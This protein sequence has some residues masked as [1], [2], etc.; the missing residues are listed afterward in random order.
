M[1]DLEHIDEEMIGQWNRPGDPMGHLFK[2]DGNAGPNNIEGPW[3]TSDEKII[4]ANTDCP[5]WTIDDRY[6]FTYQRLTN[7]WDG[8]TA[9]RQMVESVQ[10]LRNAAVAS[11]NWAPVRAYFMAN[12]DY[13][14]TM[15]YIAIRNWAEPWDDVFH[16]H[17][18]YQ[19]ATD[20]KWLVIA[21][22]KDM[23]FGE[24][25]GWAAGK[26]FYIGEEGN[27][28]NRLG[29]NMLKD[30][31]IKAFRAELWAR[32]VELDATGPLNPT[33]YGAKVDAAASVFS[34]TDY[35]ASPAASAVCSFPAELAK[36]RTYGQCRHPDILDVQDAAA[37]TATTCG[38]KGDYYQTM[39]GD[40]TQDFTKATL[41]L[42]R[43]D[44]RVNFDFG[45]GSPGAG[46][47][48]DG[49]QVR[50]TGKIVPRYTETYTFYTQSDD[51]V[52][53]WVNGVQLVNKWMIQGATEWNGTISLTAGQPVTVVMEYFDSTTTAS[54]KL[55]WSSATQCK[56]PIPTGRL[57]PM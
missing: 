25:F 10:T 6:R 44:P 26:S 50:W 27:P 42:S 4:V 2:A 43:V 21:Q 1:M 36:M 55:L 9:L 11:G 12:F 35:L 56:Q 8:P 45:T 28:D 51:G 3:S 19:R 18:L 34:L 30:A 40:A 5:M 20:G 52:R 38:L 14:K 46:V 23:E 7:K 41:K 13:Q 49:F 39:A 48:T 47:P 17:F 15:D 16:N 57:L 37:C 32:I 33:N 31:F 29:W 22:D 53:L 54:A 24:F